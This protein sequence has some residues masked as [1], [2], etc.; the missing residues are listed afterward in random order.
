[1]RRRTRGEAGKGFSVVAEEIRK[2]AED[3]ADQSRTIAA[4][5]KATIDSIK[6]IAQATEAINGSVAEIVKSSGENQEAIDVLVDITG[7]FVL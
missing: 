7:K 3:S 4:G 2:L 5:L 6:S 1:M